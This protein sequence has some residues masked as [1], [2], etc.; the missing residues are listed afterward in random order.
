MK[1]VGKMEH[2]R[3]TGGNGKKGLAKQVVHGKSGLPKAATGP[4]AQNPSK[5][6]SQQKAFT[7]PDSMYTKKVW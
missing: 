3:T 2:G 7:G 1:L 4:N 6:K 5:A